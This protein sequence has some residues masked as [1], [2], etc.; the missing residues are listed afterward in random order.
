[1][2]SNVNNTICHFRENNINEN[3]HIYI[4]GIF[5]DI[6]SSSNDSKK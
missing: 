5:S 4:Y 3:N 2:E 6:T 1:M